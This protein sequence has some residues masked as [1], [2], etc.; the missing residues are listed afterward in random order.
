MILKENPDD[1]F[2]HQRDPEYVYKVNNT[3]YW[4]NIPIQTAIKVPHNK[5]DIAIW[6]QEK[7]ICTIV[8]V[9]Y[10]ADVNISRKIDEKLNSY[11]RLVKNMQIMYSDYK[12]VVVPIIIGALG[13]VPKCLSKYMFQLGFDNLEINGLIR[14]CGTAK[15]CKTFLKFD[16]R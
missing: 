8:E 7:K 9:S 15:I 11:A 6:D 4:W 16:D 12:F 2:R 5:P 10:A 1:R 13:Y 3:E 14:K